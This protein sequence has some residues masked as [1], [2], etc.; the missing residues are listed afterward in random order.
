MKLAAS[1]GVYTGINS[2]SPG[3]IYRSA[4]EVAVCT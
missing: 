4:Y 1:K 2:A 3:N